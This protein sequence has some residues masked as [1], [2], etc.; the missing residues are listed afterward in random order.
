[1]K[2]MLRKLNNNLK[3]NKKINSPSNN[4]E[5]QGNKAEETIL[6]FTFRTEFS[7]LMNSTSK[8]RP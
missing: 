3:M 7:H 8:I 1:M 2:N 5:D 4:C 6:A